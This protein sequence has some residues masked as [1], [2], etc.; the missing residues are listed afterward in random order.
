MSLEKL[1]QHVVQEQHI[2]KYVKVLQNLV[3]HWRFYEIISQAV[4]QNY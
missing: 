1:T 2:E 4:Q 3:R